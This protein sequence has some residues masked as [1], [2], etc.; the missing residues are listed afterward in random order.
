MLL[1]VILGIVHSPDNNNSGNGMIHE[2]QDNP[3]MHVYHYYPLW[4]KI[5]WMLQLDI[6]T[7]VGC[8]FGHEYAYFEI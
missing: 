6:N 1:I 5:K 7:Q 2:V 4:K 8:Y 3:P